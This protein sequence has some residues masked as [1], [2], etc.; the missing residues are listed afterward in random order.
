MIN[1][2][3]NRQST[4]KAKNSHNTISN[5]K[6]THNNPHALHSYGQKS[7][8]SQQSFVVVGAHTNV[9]KTLVSAALC[10]SFGFD[11]FKLIQAGFP[12][13][14]DIIATLSPKTRIFP[15]GITLQTPASPHIA[16]EI[17]GIEYEGL[18]IALPSS[19]NL[20]IESAGGIYTPLDS[21]FCNIDFLSANG[22]SALLV[23]GYY[24][25]GLNHILLSLQ[26]LRSRKIPLLGLVIS[27][28]GDKRMDEFLHSYYEM[29]NLKLAHFAL[30]E[31]R[32]D[33]IDGKSFSTSAQNL[34]KE[35]DTLKVF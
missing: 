2:N 30:C 13:D 12:Q 28:E 10:V 19:E 33:C 11:Y 4:Y 27:G 32:G 24:L 17:D 16:K 3:N 8:N 35:L 15:N 34:K 6:Q 9:G 5:H 14:R 26:A 18:K 29:G 1:A 22:L 21:M 23:G 20:L 25:G 7:T 31:M